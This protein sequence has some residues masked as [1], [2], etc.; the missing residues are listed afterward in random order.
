MGRSTY[1]FINLLIFIIAVVAMS[2][3]IQ[4][5]GDQKV[6]LTSLAPVLTYLAIGLSRK[7][8]RFCLWGRQLSI[9]FFTHIIIVIILGY[10]GLGFALILSILAEGDKLFINSRIDFILASAI[11]AGISLVP[12]LILRSVVH[13]TYEVFI[14]S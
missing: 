2:W 11:G 9:L 4:N 7:K 12:F 5:Y 10:L 6:W 14:K 1:V 13:G 8:N 3:V